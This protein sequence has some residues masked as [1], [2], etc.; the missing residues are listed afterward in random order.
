MYMHGA[1]Y[2]ALAAAMVPSREVRTLANGI[3]CLLHV[4]TTNHY[5]LMLLLSLLNKSDNINIYYSY[6]L[7]GNNLFFSIY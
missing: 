1:V 7:H 5:Y 2:P 6:L 4:P 3:A